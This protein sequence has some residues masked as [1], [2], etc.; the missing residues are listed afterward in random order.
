MQMQI[1]PA[2]WQDEA[3][4]GK[5]EKKESMQD[6]IISNALAMEMHFSFGHTSF[7]Q[8]MC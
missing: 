6:Y 8:G 1:R 3:I 4:R 2:S 5:K 7:R